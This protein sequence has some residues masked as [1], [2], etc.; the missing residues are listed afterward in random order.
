MTPQAAKQEEPHC[1]YHGY[2]ITIKFYLKHVEYWIGPNYMG[3]Y[4]NDSKTGKILLEWRE[5]AKE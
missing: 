5:N 3:T 1:I 4:D 2:P